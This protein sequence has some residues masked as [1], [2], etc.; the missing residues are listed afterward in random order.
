MTG[1]GF[2][3]SDG[4]DV[5]NKYVTKQYIMTYYPSLVPNM[6][7]PEVLT[8]GLDTLGSLGDGSTVNKSSPGTVAGGG[9]NWKQVTTYGGTGGVGVKTD[10]TLWTWGTN[11]GGN[12]GNLGATTASVS[13]PV[14]VSGVGVT[15]SQVGGV[16]TSPHMGAVKSD[17]TLWMWGTNTLGALGDLTTTNKSSPVTTAGGGTNWKQIYVA[18][19][20]TAAIKTDGT[21]W[22]WGG[23]S[24]GQLGNGSTALGQSSPITT[25]GGGTNWS[26][27]SVASTAGFMAAVKTDGNIWTW[28][29]NSNGQLGDGTVVAKSSPISVIGGIV[30]PWKQVAAGTAHCAAIKSDGTLW[31]WGSNSVGQLGTGGATSA[32]ASS[33]VTTAGGGTNWQQVDAGGNN[34]GGIRTDGTLWLWGDNSNGQLG[35]GVTTTSR[36]SPTTTV[37]VFQS[38]WK[39]VWVDTS[40]VAI[41]EGNNW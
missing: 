33:P 2:K 13:S 9:T 20:S 7:Q 27:V 3:D 15:W 21:L 25:S 38:D 32:S 14:Q 12:L 18:G 35:D 28:G 31:T 6:I 10:G 40:M 37:S 36:S 26:Q 11:S 19:P 30:P 16:G 1:L 5:G 29:N 39:F 41:H 24:N 17:G 8:W 22:T 23:N 4:I 34:S